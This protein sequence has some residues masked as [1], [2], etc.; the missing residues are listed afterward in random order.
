MIINITSIDYGFENL[1]TATQVIY[2]H[3]PIIDLHLR[4]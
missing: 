2:S 3:A 1:D 4:I